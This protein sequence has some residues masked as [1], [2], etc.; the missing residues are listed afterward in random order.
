MRCLF[1]PIHVGG[2]D[3]LDDGGSL[4]GDELVGV[5]VAVGVGV[6]V[7]DWLGS[8]P[9][10]ADACVGDR[11]EGLGTCEDRELAGVGALVALVAVV[12]GQVGTFVFA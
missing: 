8:V 9:V 11:S 12:T 6:G 3:G 4:A 7:G 2:S 10:G 5:G 1:R